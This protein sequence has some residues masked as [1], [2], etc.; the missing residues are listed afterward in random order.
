M[1]QWICFL[2]VVLGQFVS[3]HNQSV[4]DGTDRQ[5]RHQNQNPH[6]FIEWRY[7]ARPT[8]RLFRTFHYHYPFAFVQSGRRICQKLAGIGYNW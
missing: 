1:W 8:S 7:Q 2:I 4:D 5:Q 3:Q 6:D